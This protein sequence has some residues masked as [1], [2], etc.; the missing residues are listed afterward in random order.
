MKFKSLFLLSAL[1]LG[2]CSTNPATGAKQFTALMSPAQE[3]TVGAQ[4]HKKIAAQYGLYK[5]SAI[6]AYVSEIGQRVTQKTERPDVKYKFYVLDS[7]IVNAFALPGGYIYI[8]R[9]LLALANSEAQVAAVLAHEAGHITGRHSAERYSRGVV[10]SLGAGVLG[11]VIGSS[12]AS[13][14]LSTGANLYL[15][16]YSREQE[17]EA[18]HLGLRYMTQGGYEPDEMAKFLSSLQ[19]QSGLDAKLD[20]R[21]GGEF[22]YFSTHPATGDRVQKTVNEAKAYSNGSKVNRDGHL[23]KISG[24]IYG[25]SAAQGFIRG[26]KFYHTDLGFTFTAPD[27]FKI[28]NQTNAVIATG[29]NNRAAVVFDMGKRSSGQSAA[30]YLTQSWMKEKGLTAEN[31]TINGMRAATASFDGKLNGNASTIRL[32]AIEWKGDKFARFQIAY[33][34]NA[35]A[36]LQNDLK[37]ASYSFRSLSA[38]EKKKHRPYRVKLVTAG[39]G[40]TISTMAARLPYDDHKEERFRVLNALL[41]NEALVK[42]RVYKVIGQ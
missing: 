35:T 29:Y 23:Q 5:D 10:T 6:N 27:G 9:G 14:A 25:D 24:M 26:Q 20:G 40:D 22:S 17:H 34:K 19:A 38:A 37:S 12:A 42:G 16:S 41:P 39:A 28:K 32:I 7:P 3:N 11:A 31:I 36:E 1:M 8:S 21:K 33:P 13:Q 2:A 4:E 18:D 30:N 15:S